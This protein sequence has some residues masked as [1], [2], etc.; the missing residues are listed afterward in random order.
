MGEPKY[1][2]SDISTI[3]IAAQ[4]AARPT[5]ASPQSLRSR[6]WRN[7]PFADRRKGMLAKTKRSALVKPKA[8]EFNCS[9]PSIGQE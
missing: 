9:E 4:K 5:E 3:R 7:A 2:V 8:S 1:Y 6:R